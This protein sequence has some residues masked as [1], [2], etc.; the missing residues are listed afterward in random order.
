MVLG[1]WSFM[2]FT[3]HDLARQYLVLHTG[4]RIDAVLGSGIPPPAAA[5]L[6]HRPRY[7]GGLQGVGP[8]AIR[9]G[10][11]VTLSSTFLSAHFW[12]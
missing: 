3:N 2:A 4:N 10:A 7:P 8:S 6:R 12:R 11:A 1:G 9:S 5:L